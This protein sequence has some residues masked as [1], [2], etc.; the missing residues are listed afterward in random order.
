MIGILNLIPDY[1]SIFT[2]TSNMENLILCIIVRAKESSVFNI[3]NK[4]NT[5]STATETLSFF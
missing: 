4:D 3:S 5:Q 1:A 2:I